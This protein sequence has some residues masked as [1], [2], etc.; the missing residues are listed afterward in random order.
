MSEQGTSGEAA[1]RNEGPAAGDEV[2]QRPGPAAPET[3]S[4]EVRPSLGAPDP[5]LRPPP[6]G[7]TVVPPPAGPG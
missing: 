3:S 7:P 2:S 5:E 4:G 1:D 6:P